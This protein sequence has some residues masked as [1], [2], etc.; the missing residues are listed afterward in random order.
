MQKSIL[1]GS[2][3]QNGLEALPVIA[4]RIACEERGNNAG[5]AFNVVAR[6]IDVCDPAL[7]AVVCRDKNAVQFEVRVKG[8]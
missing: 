5:C 1:R 2:R 4:L 3:R 6:H 7:L 8:S